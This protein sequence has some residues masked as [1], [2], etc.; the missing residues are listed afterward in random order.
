M[1]WERWEPVIACCGL[2]CANECGI[3][4]CPQDPALAE[5]HVKWLQGRGFADAVPEWFHC[6]TCFGPMAEHWSA[7]CPIRSCC[8]ET[9]GLQSCGRCAEFP[10]PQLSQ[11]AASS[12]RYAHALS[13]LEEMKAAAGQM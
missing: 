2:D 8:V 3:H 7:D 6:G 4:R 12:A 11:R 13:R 9:H 10:C 1:A 5:E